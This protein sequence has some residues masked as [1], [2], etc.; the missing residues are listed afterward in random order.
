MPVLYWV[1]VNGCRWY[2]GGS[3]GGEAP[4][5]SKGF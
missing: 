4:F 3:K 2:G 1:I 5:G